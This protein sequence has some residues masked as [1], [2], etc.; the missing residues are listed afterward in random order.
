MNGAHIHLLLNHFPLIGL[1]FST[2]ILGLGLFRSN[3]EF[4]HAGLLIT[5][6]SGVLTLPTYLTGDPAEDVLKSTPGFSKSL[7]HEHEE[8]AEFAAWSIGITAVLA[9]A[10]LFLSFKKNHIPKALMIAI[11]VLQLFS[12][13]VLARVSNLGGKISHPEIRDS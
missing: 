2:V 9:A 11:V 8:A 3:K 10:A 7:V 4:V 6:I 13:V 1:F 5:A 12:L